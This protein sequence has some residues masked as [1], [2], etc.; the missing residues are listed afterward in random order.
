MGKYLKKLKASPILLVILI[1]CFVVGASVLGFFL[2]STTTL[3]TVEPFLF[4]DEIPEELLLTRTINN[5]VGGNVYEFNH[6]LNASEYIQTGI[7]LTFTWSGNDT[8]DGITPVL[9]Y[10]GNPITFLYIEPDT[11]YILTERITLNEL[12][13]SSSYECV[14]EVSV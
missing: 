14:L 3:N 7:N 13:T 1:A 10:E 8:D 9:L 12:I 6:T 5:A 2:S 4:D 11:D